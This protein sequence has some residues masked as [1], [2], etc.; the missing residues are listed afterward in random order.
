MQQANFQVDSRLATLLSQDYS[1][2]E[3]ALKELV[4][5]AW[6]ADAEEVV[7]EL[8][9][10]LTDGPIVVRDDGNGMTRQELESHYLKIASDRRMRTDGRT[11][12]KRRPIKGKKGIGKFAGLMSASVMC[13]TTMA[14]G[15]QISFT[16][17]I[18]DLESASDIEHLT[19][20]LEVSVC[21]SEDHGTCVTLTHLR[22]GLRYPSADRLRQELIMEYGRQ[23]DFK[24]II[25]GKPL[26]I[27]DLEGEF[28]E[29]R[30]TFPDA[31]DA[32]LRFAI[33]K[34]KSGLRRPGITLMV[35]GKAVGKPGFFGLENSDEIPA[36]LLRKLYGEVEADGLMD[37]VTA[38]WDS[39]IEN[40]EAYLQI[41]TFVQ[42]N[43][44][45]AFRSTHGMEMRMAHARL[46]K[47]V[48]GRL[49]K[50]PQH[51]REFADRAIKKVLKKYYDEP[52]HKVQA[53]AFVV[54]EAV[55][56]TEY[57]SIVEHLAEANRGD[58]VNLADALESFGLA[59]MA[60]LV[61][62]ARARL[63]FLDDLERL[64][65]NEGCLESTVHKAIEVNLWILGAAF[66]IFSSNIT[67][68]RQ[69]EE[70]L[71]QK[72][73]GAQG[74][75]R[76]DLLLNES[77]LGEFLLIEFK[78]PSHPLSFADYQ[79]A[80]RY[81]HELTGYSS[82]PIKVL[83]IG[84]RIDGF[85]TRELEPGVSCL[86]FTDIISTARRQIEWQLQRAPGFPGSLLV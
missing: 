49:E 51:K 42:E 26:G 83:V 7:I 53:L 2:T 30:G 43:L 84:G 33:S 44:V 86:L 77:L 50:L 67:L 59:D 34:K 19:L 39:V 65:R 58:I 74:T 16:L 29:V 28:T 35:E 25:N 47:A 36:R 52:A 37:Y 72:Y 69:I 66:T 41:V 31:G 62:Q 64:V 32:T 23:K 78:R 24:I 79:Q 73:S 27:D 68:K 17:G 55:E 48:A 57:R 18:Q 8:P 85:P 38:G 6:D 5:N 70:L 9:E 11:S 61:D 75:T 76:P 81:R 40:S 80:T 20:P 71:K 22:Q 1:T 21:S 56:R 12:K 4:D 63:Q 15:Q 82:K 14:R 60:V 46:Q 3:K 13:L 54:L 45:E 10:P